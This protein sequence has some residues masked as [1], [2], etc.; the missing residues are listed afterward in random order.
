MRKVLKLFHSLASC[1]RIGALLGYTIVLI[2]APQ[3]SPLAYAQARQI[4]SLLCNFLLLPSLAVALVTGLFSMMVH[5]P[6]QDT[7]WAWFKA[8]LGLSMFEATLGIIQSKA[9]TAAVESAKI[10]TGETEPVALADALANEWGALTAIMALS[11]A[12]VGL[13]V[14]RPRLARR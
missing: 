13:G 6:F 10:A 4:I 14:W 12:Q 3:T 2:H 7:R 5:R 9:T 11:I 8:V 1:G